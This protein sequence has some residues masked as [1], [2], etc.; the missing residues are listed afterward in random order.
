MEYP[1]YERDG[2]GDGPWCGQCRPDL[3]AEAVPPEVDSPCNC[4]ACGRLL[5]HS[6]TPD[7]VRYVLDAALEEVAKPA[8]QRN[9]RRNSPPYYKRSR[10]VDVVRD[11]V[12]DLKDHGLAEFERR[13]VEWF[14]EFTA[15]PSGQPAA[16][17][18]N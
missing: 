8:A 6:L 17:A 5:Q 3:E 15:E 10:Q 4:A 12:D 18:A 11:W 7:G 1:R 14:L 9:R 16:T 13:F 2:N